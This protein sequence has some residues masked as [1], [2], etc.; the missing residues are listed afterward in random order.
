[1][2]DMD[3]QG[4]IYVTGVTGEPFSPSSSSD[5]D[6][7][8]TQAG[9]AEVATP[10]GCDF[11]FR[12]IDQ[13]VK[14]FEALGAK[15][16]TEHGII[17]AS[18]KKLS[19][20][21]IYLDIVSV[22]A[23]INLILTA[24]RVDGITVIENAAKEPHIVDVANFLNAMGANIKGAGTD[25]IKIMGVKE[26]KGNATYSMIPDQIEAGTFMIVA[27]AT[28]GDITVK[29]IIPKHMESLTAKLMELNVN[30]IEG[31]DEIRVKGTNRLKSINLKTLAYPGFPTDLQPQMTVLLTQAEGTSKLSEDVWSNRF[32]YIDELERMGSKI[33]VNG[34]MAVI[35]GKTK[36]SAAPIKAL[37][38][39]AGAAVVIAA[40]V[41]EGETVISNIEFIDRGYENFDDKIRALGGQIKRVKTSVDS[42]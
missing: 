4:N 40:L 13:H 21:Q 38:L 17:K 26:L 30:V 20:A 1:M 31:E 27:A 35:E 23:T 34:S 11:G 36:L 3:D 32:Q 37:D 25:L 7:P 24:V 10:G 16:K 33:T 2:I 29:N 41:A 39:R 8:T 12:P 15:L 42:V 19:G 6:Q 14:G 28:G 5:P 22:G 9:M 18:S